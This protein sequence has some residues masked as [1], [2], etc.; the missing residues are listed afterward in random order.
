MHYAS[1]LYKLRVLTKFMCDCLHNN[2]EK[3]RRRFLCKIN[4]VSYPTVCT[5]QLITRSYL[6]VVVVP[7]LR[8]CQLYTPIKVKK[9]FSVQRFC[10]SLDR[11]TWCHG[12]RAPLLVT[13][14]HVCRKRYVAT[15][16]HYWDPFEGQLF[17]FMTA[18]Q[19]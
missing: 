4:W 3:G 15:G 18:D 9:K 14:P 7:M 1:I 19:F 6:S 13:C 17:S 11:W 16:R 2:T 10:K 8:Y 12:E 5:G